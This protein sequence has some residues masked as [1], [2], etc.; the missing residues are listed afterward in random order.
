MNEYAEHDC[1]QH[2]INERVDE[3]V[4]ELDETTG[5]VEH[6]HDNR[7]D[8]KSMHDWSPLS[9]RGQSILAH[10]VLASHAGSATVLGSEPNQ[11]VAL[12]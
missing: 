7:S 10:E 8:Q 2:S 1:E 3:S 12:I 9:I 11:I 6:K 5:S 4:V